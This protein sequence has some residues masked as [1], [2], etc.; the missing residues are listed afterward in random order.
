MVIPSVVTGT[1]QSNFFYEKSP[2]V[3]GGQFEFIETFRIRFG[4]F[5]TAPVFSNEIEWWTGNAIYEEEADDGSLG[6]RD[7]F[8]RDGILLRLSSEI[9]IRFKA[10]P[11]IDVDYSFS[12]LPPGLVA[13]WAGDVSFGF[14][15]SNHHLRFF[16]NG[17]VED[18]RRRVVTNTLI[19]KPGIIESVYRYEHGSGETQEDLSYEYYIHLGDLTQR[20][21]A[22]ERFLSGRWLTGG[23]CGIIGGRSPGGEF[24]S[25]GWTN[26]EIG[27]LNWARAFE[28]APWPARSP[29]SS[30][31]L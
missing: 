14:L 20:R 4:E 9:P 29:I 17:K 11:E 13:S 7:P 22:G 19:L 26:E 8:S 31:G 24:F 30:S 2:L 18:H 12:G 15:L 5:I 21:L 10:N 28:S 16:I 27:A 3:K 25:D 1:A 6:P 23:R